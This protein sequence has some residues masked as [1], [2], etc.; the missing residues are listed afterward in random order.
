MDRSRQ[1]AV[2]DVLDGK[3]YNWIDDNPIIG[4]GS[5]VSVINENTGSIK[6]FVVDYVNGS[7]PVFSMEIL[8]RHIGDII[9]YKGEKYKVTEIKY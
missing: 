1:N 4:L 8:G 5:N 7:L 6:S 9:T 2:N 3:T